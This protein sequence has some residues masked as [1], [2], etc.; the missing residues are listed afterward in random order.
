MIR[1]KYNFYP[2][3]FSCRI[4]ETISLLNLVSIG[5]NTRILNIYILTEGMGSFHQHNQTFLSPL[6]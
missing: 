6:N 2:L 3:S 5:L 1:D 4:E